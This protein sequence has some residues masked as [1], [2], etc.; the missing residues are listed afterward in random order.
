MQEALFAELAAGARSFACGGPSN[1]GGLP[2]TSLRRA[3]RR[4]R[5]ARSLKHDGGSGSAVFSSTR[6][7]RKH[8]PI[9][10]RLAGKSFFLQWR[11]RASGYWSRD[12]PACETRPEVGRRG[13]D[14]LN[15]GILS[16]QPCGNP[17]AAATHFR[18]FHSSQRSWIQREVVARADREE[19]LHHM[20]SLRMHVL[21]G[22]RWSSRRRT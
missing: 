7:L 16:S 9:Q 1:A 2:T 22:S 13:Y 11:S 5:C 10:K 15:F 21:I 6:P 3:G 20:G 8:L 14:Q 17:S 19:E 4:R 18:V 12:L